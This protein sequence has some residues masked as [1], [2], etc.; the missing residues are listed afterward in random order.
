MTD[1]S[2]LSFA[3][4]RA[5]QEQIKVELKSREAQEL[6]KARDQILAIAQSVGLPL[7]EL[8]AKGGKKGATGPAPVKFKH[9]EDP[10]KQWTGRGRQPKWIKEWTDSG[11]SEDALRVA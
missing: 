5:L 9:P 8:I 3:D 2:S 11:K 4:L 1:L 6:K 7:E 10:S